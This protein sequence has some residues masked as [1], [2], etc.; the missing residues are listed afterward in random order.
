MFFYG[1]KENKEIS[2]CVCFS[3]AI[4]LIGV[5]YAASNRCN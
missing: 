4:V 1:V 5:I 2:L 3:S